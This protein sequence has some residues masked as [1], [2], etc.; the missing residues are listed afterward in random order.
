MSPRICVHFV[1]NLPRV[2]LHVFSTLVSKNATQTHAINVYWM[3]RLLLRK[4]DPIIMGK[5]II[6]LVIQK[7]TLENA[8]FLKNWVFYVSGSEG[9]HIETW[10]R[11]VA[12][13]LRTTFFK[14]YALS[15]TDCDCNLL[16]DSNWQAIGVALDIGPVSYRRA[17]TWANVYK[18]PWCYAVSQSSAWNMALAVRWQLL[19]HKRR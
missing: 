16:Y 5:T 19:H 9:K 18:V 7:S 13:S 11:E 8:K 15:W 12:F 17:I 10:P 3:Q 14:C 6:G 1:H 2:Q 4:Y